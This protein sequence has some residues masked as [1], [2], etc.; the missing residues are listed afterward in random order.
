MASSRLLVISGSARRGSLNRQLAAAASA[1]A[2]QQG[3]EVTELDL[4]AL[5]LPLYDGD[6]EAALGVPLGAATL[7][8]ALRVSDALLLVTPEYNG[9]PPP[10]LINAFDW[11]SRLPAAGEL[12]SGLAVTANKPV[13]LLAA[14]P[15]AL[16]GLRSLGF[17]RQY[18]QMAF[19]MLVVPQQQ[20]LSRAHEAFD[21]EGQ[22]RDAR[23][24][25][26]VGQ[27]VG[28]LLTLAHQLDTRLPESRH[29]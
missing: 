14:S 20:A 13:A 25:A 28:Q 17:V 3:A 27:V 23:T 16:G 9:F 4:R 7:R 22:L 2:R 1:M 6:L 24:A 10:L 12:P 26:G 8:D 21:A 15:G 29:D 5:D 11:L 19:A 18:L